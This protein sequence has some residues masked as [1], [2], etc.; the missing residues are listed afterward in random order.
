MIDNFK[1]SLAAAQ[2]EYESMLGEQ[3]DL[4]R[5]IQSN[6]A[7]KEQ[8]VIRIAIIKT[9]E[10]L[11]SENRNLLQTKNEYKETKKIKDE[12]YQ[13]ENAILQEITKDL[14]I[15]QQDKKQMEEQLEHMH[16]ESINNLRETIKPLEETSKEIEEQKERAMVKK[17]MME[18]LLNETAE[19]ESMLLEDLSSHLLQRV[20]YITRREEIELVCEEYKD[21][22]ELSLYRSALGSPEART[23]LV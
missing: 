14:E 6:E 1:D 3:Q 17:K 19:E 4:Q 21:A 22:E 20:D 11:K 18:Q 16:A 23:I 13:A 7:S 9:E 10:L 15:L 12:I 8:Q 5:L 2:S